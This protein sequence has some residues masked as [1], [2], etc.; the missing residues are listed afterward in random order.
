MT[1]WLR[2]RPRSSPTCPT[3]LPRPSSCAR[4]TSS[5][6][7]PAGWR[8]SSVRSASASPLRPATSAYGVPSVLAQFACEVK[9]LRAVGRGRVPPDPQR[10]LGPD[11]PDPHR[12]GPIGPR[13]RLVHDAFAHRRKALAGSLALASGAEPDIRERARDALVALGHPPTSAPSGSPPATSGIWR[14]GCG[15]D[16]AAPSPRAR[17]TSACCSARPGPTAATSS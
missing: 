14:G 17:S 3:E 4:S 12:A 5:L 1:A 13:A 2:R 11:R 16:A 10:R 7:S 9:V 8:W 15:R 6:A